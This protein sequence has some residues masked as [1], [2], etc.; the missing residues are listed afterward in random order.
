MQRCW[1]RFLAAESQAW[2]T[3]CGS[4]TVSKYSGHNNYQPT[5]WMPHPARKLSKLFTQKS[6]K[7]R[8][9][10]STQD[11]M[12]RKNPIILLRLRF[13]SLHLPM[14][15]SFGGPSLS[16]AIFPMFLLRKR[17]KSCN[18]SHFRARAF[19]PKKGGMGEGGGGGG[20]GAS[21]PRSQQC[22]I[23]ETSAPRQI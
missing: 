5:R 3:K 18:Q 10:I 21:C 1:L 7:G 9:P 13:R 11:R 6:L 17:R 14:L 8:N 16:R 20:M 15:C 19:C 22:W 2:T 23:S 12:I 4:M